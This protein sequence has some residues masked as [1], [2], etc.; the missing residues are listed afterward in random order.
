MTVA[1]NVVSVISVTVLV[2]DDVCN[3]VKTVICTLQTENLA[4]H[5]E[6][7]CASTAIS[8]RHTNIE[9]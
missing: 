3:N 1:T 9:S 8:F 5:E 4:G 7:G 2:R 6:D